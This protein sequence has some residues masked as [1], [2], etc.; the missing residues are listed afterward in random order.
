MQKG[1]WA[2]GARYLDAIED[3]HASYATVH[4]YPHEF[5]AKNRELIRKVNLRL[6]Y[7]LQL[8]EASWPAEVKPGEALL[9]GYSWQNA[10]VAPCLPGGHPAITLKDEKNGIAGVFVDE[11][12]DMR[13]LP[14]GPPGGATPIG[15]E[16]R[17][18]YQADKPLIAFSLPP[19]HILKPGLYS[20]YISVG[21]SIGTPLIALPLENDDGFRRYR[22]G[23]IRIK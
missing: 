23:S 6:G 2:D 1:Y 21:D 13:S 20:I 9:V 3:Y 11:E 18:H 8:L 7:R 22:L 14:V 16:V 5:L 19:R 15:R 4:W 10:G 12:F 17:P